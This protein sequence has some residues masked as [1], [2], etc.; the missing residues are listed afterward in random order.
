[1]DF[2]ANYA[3]SREIIECLI[4]FVLDILRNSL[5]WMHSSTKSASLRCSSDFCSPTGDADDQFLG[6]TNRTCG[7]LSPRNV[8]PTLRSSNVERWYRWNVT[9]VEESDTEQWGYLQAYFP[10]EWGNAR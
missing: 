9:I 7:S 6:F 2:A 8:G 1:M 4:G 3:P 10:P 5:C